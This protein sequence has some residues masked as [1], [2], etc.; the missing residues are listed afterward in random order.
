MKV[1]KYILFGIMIFF[2][3][4]TMVLAIKETDYTGDEDENIVLADAGNRTI[5]INKDTIIVLQ[6]CELIIILFC[7]KKR[8]MIL[9][10]IIFLIFNIV[11][12]MIPIKHNYDRWI[13]GTRNNKYI[14]LYNYTLKSE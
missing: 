14:N 10:I 11:I 13:G 4:I 3:L 8:I 7:F 12:F 5:V 2:I 1:W 6:I 9:P